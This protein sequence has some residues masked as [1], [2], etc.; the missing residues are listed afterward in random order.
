[1]KI[2]Q[3]EFG[4]GCGLY[5]LAN[6]LQKESIIT[7]QRLNESQYGNNTGQ[8][9]KWLIEDGFNLFLEPLYFNCFGGKL[10]I[11]VSSIKPIGEDVISIPVCIDVQKTEESKKHFIAAE[12]TC[13]GKLFVMDSLRSEA[14]ITTL[15]EFQN[16][17]L[18]V[19]GLWHFRGYMEDGYFMRMK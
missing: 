17:Y 10:P 18:I 2:F 4:Y 19:N 3:Q 8:L 5:S 11:D 7:R 13:E 15:T 16:D 14:F 12:I 6:A 9:N 1:M